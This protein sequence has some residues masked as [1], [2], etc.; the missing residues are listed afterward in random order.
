MPERTDCK[1]NRYSRYS[2]IATCLPEP[3]GNHRFWYG[4]YGWEREFYTL[5]PYVTSF[6]C[7]HSL[8]LTDI[9]ILKSYM[10]S[11]KSS[12]ANLF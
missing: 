7:L 6:M 8:R 9:C 3:Y 1:E 12:Y 2:S 10:L 4:S 11:Q 5:P